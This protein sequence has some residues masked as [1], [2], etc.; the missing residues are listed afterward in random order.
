MA[1]KTLG[2][3]RGGVIRVLVLGI[4]TLLLALL[5]FVLSQLLLKQAELHTWLAR[6]I[7]Q[8]YAGLIQVPVNAGLAFGL[9]CVLEVVSGEKV[10]FEA[11]SVK[12]SGA[13]GP[14]VLWVFAFLA[15]TF[16]TYLLWDLPG[17]AS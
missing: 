11:F 5:L 4:T 10:E 3:L 8:R 15:I 16:A 9:I 6:L 2:S 14:V 1:E 17:I 7:Q 13:S 12:F